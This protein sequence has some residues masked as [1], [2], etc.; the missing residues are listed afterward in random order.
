MKYANYILL[1]RAPMGMVQTAGRPRWTR[2]TMQGAF[3]LLAFV[4]LFALFEYAS[5]LTGD[6][7]ASLELNDLFDQALD[8]VYLP[9]PVTPYRASSTLKPTLPLPESCQDAYFAQGKLCYNPHPPPLDILWTWVNGS[10]IILQD[11]KARIVDSF[12]PDA[13][14]RPNKSWKQARQFRLVVDDVRGHRDSILRI[15]TTMNCV[16]PCVQF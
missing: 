1:L 12:P 7:G 5:Y 4:S 6:E 10:D 3:L 15:G 2:R 11:A 8:A 9:F 13:A 16:I 14:Y